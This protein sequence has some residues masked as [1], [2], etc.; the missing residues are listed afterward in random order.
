MLLSVLATAASVG[1]LVSQLTVIGELRRAQ[2]T[3]ARVPIVQSLASFLNSVLW[4]KYGLMRG[5]T[6]VYLVNGLGAIIAVYI[7][8]CFW[9]YASKRR[10]VEYG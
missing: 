9:F 7:L 2:A 10:Q 4:V 8:G 5:D 3:Q 1:M 6:A